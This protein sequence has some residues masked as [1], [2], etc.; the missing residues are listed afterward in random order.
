[1]A[2]N[3][4]NTKKSNI[5][6]IIFYLLLVTALGLSGFINYTYFESYG[7]PLEPQMIT[8]E[9]DDLAPEI[10]D[11]YVEKSELVALEDAYIKLKNQKA[12]ADKNVTVVTPMQMPSMINKDMRKAKDSVQCS[13]MT[14]ESFMMPKR[15][16]DKIIKYVKKH[17]DAKYFEVI[18]LVDN[19][20]FKLF[21]NIKKNE[22]LYRKMGIGKCTVNK[23]KK[24]TYAG[25]ATFRAMEASWVI[26]TATKQKAV[27]H[28]AHYKLVSKKGNRGVVV[29][30]YN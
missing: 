26:K 3:T 15:C 16:E 17:K 30:A 7:N 11:V 1:M 21:N 25:L 13:N 5:V 10:K 14:K 4:N 18:G 8:Y 23:L 9:F 12:A 22:A 20:E 24:Y 27:T 28:N 6:H 2:D 29:R 19:S